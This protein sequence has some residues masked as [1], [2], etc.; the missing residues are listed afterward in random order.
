MAKYGVVQHQEEEWKPAQRESGLASIGRISDRMTSSSGPPAND[1]PALDSLPPC[2]PVT[3][4]EVRLLHQ[5]HGQQILA[6][7]A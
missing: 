5:Y 2:L 3:E 7:F 6:L 4:D 1:N